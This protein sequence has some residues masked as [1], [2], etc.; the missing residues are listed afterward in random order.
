[1]GFLGIWSTNVLHLFIDLSFLLIL[2]AI[3]GEWIYSY[4]WKCGSS[5]SSSS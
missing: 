4:W 2:G 1:M 5:A 3:I